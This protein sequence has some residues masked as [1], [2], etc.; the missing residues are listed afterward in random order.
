MGSRRTLGDL[1]R[2]GH[3]F[4]NYLWRVPADGSRA[5]ERIEVAG[6]GA[7]SPATVFSRD[8]LAFAR[9]STDIDLYR[10]L[11]GRPPEVVAASSFPEAE[12]ALSADGRRLAFTSTRSA[13]AL[14]IWVSG[15]DGSDPQQLTR[16]ANVRGSPSWSPD[17]RHLAFDSRDEDRHFHIWIMDADGAN[18][19][20]LTADPG[21]QNKPTW[22]RDGQW[23]YFSWGQGNQRDIWRMHPAGGLKERVTRGG[24]GDLGQESADGT[25]VL[26]QQKEAD[27]PLLAQPLNGGAPQPLIAC[28]SQLAFAVAATGI[29]YLPCLR[30]ASDPPLHLLDPDTGSDRVLGTLDKYSQGFAVFTVSF[31]GRII[32]YGRGRDASDLMLI[33]NFR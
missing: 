1:R 16:G 11:A 12:A 21:D 14:Q 22:S 9:T 28:V 33:E 29:Y 13:D 25:R 6:L 4:L 20:Q 3:A 17:A 23:I 18:P 19:R 24:A 31:D 5:P 27:G 10:F 7:A 26:Y 32:L 15:A 30:D 2:N 8:R